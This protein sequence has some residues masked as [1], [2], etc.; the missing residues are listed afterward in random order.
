MNAGISKGMVYNFPSKNNMERKADVYI[1]R[2]PL[3]FE[4]LNERVAY[5]PLTGEFTWKVAPCRR[6]KAGESAGTFKGAPKKGMSKRY[7]YIRVLHYETPATRVAWLLQTGAW[8]KG[9]ILYKDGDTTNLRWDNLKEGDDP[10]TKSY[11]ES[12]RVSYKMSHGYQRK[13]ALKRYYGL[14]LETYNVMLAAQNGVCAICGGVETYI[15]KGHGTPKPLS[16]DHNHDTGQIRG[17]LC[18]HCNYLIGFCKEDR[19]ALLA[20]I[21]YLDK[22]AVRPAVTPALTIVPAEAHA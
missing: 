15:P 20:A 4:Q 6:M 21:K 2:M 22:H 8:P 17:L 5:D 12:G 3:T 14:S 10:P 13:V 19:N 16:V 11:D 1:K 18:S 7:K 9:N